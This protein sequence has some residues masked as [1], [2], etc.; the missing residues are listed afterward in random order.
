L[1]RSQILERHGESVLPSCY[2]ASCTCRFLD[3]LTNR[4]PKRLNQTAIYTK[5]DG[6]VD[7]QVCVTGDPS[8]DYEVAGTHI[9]MVFNPI[10][11]SIVAHRLA[12]KRPPP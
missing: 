9:G 1:V 8:V 11:F 12:G 4:L 7:W 10:V 2:T 6:I 5:S 3:S